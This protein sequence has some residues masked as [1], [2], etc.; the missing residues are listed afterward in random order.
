MQIIVDFKFQ[1]YIIITVCYSV[2]CSM[3]VPVS[4]DMHISTKHPT[5]A[6]CRVVE[7]QVRHAEMPGRV[8]STLVC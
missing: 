3:V 1:T 8:M 5:V 4:V 6:L 7:I 2:P